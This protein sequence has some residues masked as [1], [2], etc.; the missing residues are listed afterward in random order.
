M[1]P[2]EQ[3]AGRRGRLAGGVRLLGGQAVEQIGGVQAEPKL[4]GVHE[5]RELEIFVFVG[6]RGFDGAN[7]DALDLAL[8]GLTLVELF[9]DLQD[10]FQVLEQL[11]L[12]RVRKD[13]D[14]EHLRTLRVLLDRRVPVHLEAF[15]IDLGEL[16]GRARD[17]HLEADVATELRG[18]THQLFALGDLLLV[19]FRDRLHDPLHVRLFEELEDTGVGDGFEGGGLAGRSHDEDGIL[20]SRALRNRDRGA[21]PRG[22]ALRLLVG[23]RGVGLRGRG[24][25]LF[26]G[27]RFRGRR[28][29]RW[30]GDGQLA[31]GQDGERERER[32]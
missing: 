15:E 18:D 2:V 20:R 14:A 1:T 32:Q 16:L 10:L 11:V 12:L 8:A 19:A 31:S 7:L 9:E 23:R 4:A 27:L 29:G 5:E 30:L 26:G 3:V 13:D 24:H 25:G 17:S 6:E 28:L 21:G 22:F